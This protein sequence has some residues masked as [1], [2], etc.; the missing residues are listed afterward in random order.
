MD[1][2]DRLRSLDLPTRPAQP[3]LQPGAIL[4]REWDGRDHRVMVLADGFAFEGKT[5]DSLSRVA[6]AIRTTW[7][8]PRFFGLRAATQSAGQQ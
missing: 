2:A 3:E 8:G 5:Y 1:Q 4:T 7:N 6:L